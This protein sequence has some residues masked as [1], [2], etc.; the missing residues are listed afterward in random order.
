MDAPHTFRPSERARFEPA[1]MTKVDLYG[2]ERLLVGLNC[3][4]PGQAHALHTHAGSDKVYVIVEGRAR[5][6]LAATA[7]D[8]EAGAVAVAPS[9]V[10]HAL[11]NAGSGRLTVLVLMAPPPR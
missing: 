10:P 2:S 9:G 11:E 7:S 3:F 1:R 4:E 5:F 8:L 6:T